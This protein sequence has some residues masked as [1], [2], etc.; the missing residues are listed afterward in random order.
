[1]AEAKKS[2]ELQRVTVEIFGDV[3]HLRTDDPEGLK[4]L[5]Q[6]VDSTMREMS[7]NTHSFVSSRIATLA[8]LKIAED[9]LQLKKDYDELL[10]MLH[11]DK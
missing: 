5:V 7:Q 6:I 8:A 3:Y 11:E 4:K 2:S 1:M 9:Y 10:N